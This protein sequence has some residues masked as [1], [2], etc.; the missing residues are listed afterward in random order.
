[1]IKLRKEQLQDEG[2]MEKIKKKRR[3]DFLDVLLFAKVSMY[4]KGLRVCLG[5]HKEQA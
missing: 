5:T 2:E 4:S 3:L 1:M